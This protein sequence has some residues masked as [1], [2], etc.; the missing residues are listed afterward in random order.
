[1]KEKKYNADRL[2]INIVFI[3]KIKESLFN[4]NKK[5]YNVYKISVEIIITETLDIYQEYIDK[6]INVTRIDKNIN[7]LCNNYKITLN[8]YRDRKEEKDILLNINN[9]IKDDNEYIN[10]IIEVCNHDMDIFNKKIFK[11]RERK[12]LYIEEKKEQYFEDILNKI[13]E[14]KQKIET[15]NVDEKIGNIITIKEEYSKKINK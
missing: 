14:N 11:L 15:I 1:M 4:I 5:K 6:N 9:N 8:K 7:E 13:K 12:R 10:D 3:N 2:I